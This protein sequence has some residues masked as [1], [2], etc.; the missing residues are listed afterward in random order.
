[1]APRSSPGPVEVVVKS[2]AA[3]AGAALGI[4]LLWGIRSLILPVAVGGLLAYI[5][6]P[7]VA[8][9]ERYRV[10]RGL[11]I[12]LLLLA[13]VSATILIVTLVRSGV[14]TEIRALDFKTRLLHKVNE[15]YK[16][17]MG[18][19]SSPTG[20]RIYQ[21]AHDD[22][23]PIVDR[24]NRLL[25]ITPEER[26]KFLDAHSRIDRPADSD[27]LLAYDRSNL[28]AL[29][30]TLEKRGLKAGSDGGSGA[31]APSGARSALRQEK[32]PLAS[33]AGI[34]S[35][36]VIAPTVFLFL[37][38]DTGEIKRSFLRLIPNRLFEPTLEVLAD[39]DGALGSY[40][41]GVVLECLLLSL[42]LALLFAAVGIPILWAVALGFVAGATN[43]IPYVGSAVALLVGLTYTLLAD[44]I[45]PLLPM[46]KAE[47]VALWLIV[48]V[49][50]VEIFKNV[51]LEPLVLGGAAKLH[52]LVVV[53]G[54]LGSGILFGLPGVLLA[55]PT[56]T[57]VKAFVSSAS[58]QLKAYGLA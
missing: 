14:P 36:W 32:T 55:I 26:A 24:V 30:Q 20:N 27:V 10:T 12:G 11:A 13:F 21:F 35:T 22:L 54:V 31:V 3:I 40:L 41:R 8:G 28:Q 18:L 16:D 52:P 17:L 29:L 45:H 7:L 56:I 53:I 48:G 42:A 47:N 9:L 4:W 33:L 15:R 6:Y 38:L 50:L 46:V 1:M 57:I 44:E 39:L 34:L 23:D 58:R 51:V 49:L 5:C 19:D 43:V 2:V 25:A 37:L